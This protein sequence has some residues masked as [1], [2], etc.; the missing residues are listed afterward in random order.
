MPDTTERAVKSARRWDELWRDDLRRPSA[1]LGPHAPSGLATTAVGLELSSYHGEDGRIDPSIARLAATLHCGRRTIERA[2]GELRDKEWLEQVVRPGF[3]SL[4]ILR[5]PT[6]GG[7]ANMT[8]PLRQYGARDLH[9]TLIDTNP[10]K[11]Y[12]VSGA[13]GLS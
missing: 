1:E 6:R 7:Y 9:E 8:H 10:R 2:L 13:R 4:W 3:R 11:Q 12:K 5:N